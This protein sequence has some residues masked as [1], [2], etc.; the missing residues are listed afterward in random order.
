MPGLHYVTVFP[1][2]SVLGISTT[3]AG[4][5]AVLLG[6][7]V[8]GNSRYRLEVLSP[9]GSVLQTKEIPGGIDFGA[10]DYHTLKRAIG[11]PCGSAANLARIPDEYLFPLARV[12]GRNITGCA[13][14]RVNLAQSWIRVDEA[15]YVAPR[16]PGW[17]V[18]TSAISPAGM[19]RL[20]VERT[21]DNAVFVSELLP[22]E[23]KWNWLPTPAGVA[24]HAGE[25]WRELILSPTEL[26]ARFC[27]G[28]QVNVPVDLLGRY[29][30]S[31][32][33]ACDNR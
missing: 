25:T 26:K 9:N 31:K 2:A 33:S 30:L 17:T 20:E 8:T 11:P 13:V 3:S 10:F 7:L 27:S 29:G 16:M 28:G 6:D 5:I 32:P 4:D 19:V 1:G 15:Q 21:K 22:G 23:P 14:L 12:H 24:I 18:H